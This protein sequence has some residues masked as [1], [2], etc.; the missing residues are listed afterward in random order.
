MAQ[1]R[2]GSLWAYDVKAEDV[3]STKRELPALV[4]LGDEAFTKS[5]S[6]WI[7]FSNKEGSPF[8]DE[9]V[10]AQTDMLIDR[11]LWIDTF[12][13][14]SNF[15]KDGLNAETRWHTH[16]SSG[17]DGF[18]IDPKN[19]KELGEGAKNFA[20]SP[21]EAK[22][23]LQAAGFSKAIESIF[24]YTPNGYA[25]TYVKQAEVAKGMLEANGDFK[26]TFNTPDYS[27]EWLASGKYHYGN[28]NYD[29]LVQ[30]ASNTYPEIDGHLEGLLST[31]PA[32]ASGTAL[33]ILR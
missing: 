10:P 18:W 19:E 16:V 23:L 29:G 21:S 30:G 22:K 28:G 32:S 7:G 15:A 27:T 11:D 13:N 14:V 1:F 12:Y 26:F 2:A 3:I 31:A 9:R 20:Y 4:L 8:R 17:E 6:P 5:T 25:A 33:R 24:S